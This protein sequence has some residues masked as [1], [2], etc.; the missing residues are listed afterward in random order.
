MGHIIAEQ[1]SAYGLTLSYLKEALDPL[2]DNG[3][4]IHVAVG[5]LQ[6]IKQLKVSLV[7]ISYNLLITFFSLFRGKTLLLT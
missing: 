3:K 1:T 5:V 4:A 6:T 2:I 7:F